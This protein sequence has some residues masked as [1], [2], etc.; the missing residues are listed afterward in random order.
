MA[1]PFYML[2]ISCRYESNT[3]LPS[4]P[5]CGDDAWTIDM[6]YEEKNRAL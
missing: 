5:N 4:C 1:I 6:P 3:V 2:C